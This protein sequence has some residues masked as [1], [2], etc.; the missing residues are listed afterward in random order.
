MS[1]EEYLELGQIQAMEGKF[2]AAL[3]NLTQA[4]SMYIGDNSSDK[5]S[6]QSLEALPSALLSY[7]GLCIAVMEN[8]VEEGMRLCQ[9]AVTKDILRP[10][11]YL[12]LGK[13]Y[14][15]AKQKDRAVKTFRRGIQVTEKNAELIKELEKLG[16]RREP[17]LPFL[18]RRNFLNRYLGRIRQGLTKKEPAQARR[19]RS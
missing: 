7:Y 8:R 15:Q 5:I 9:K 1:K 4:M 16:I 18:P 3:K 10:D 12:N 17:V 2:G 14:L 13:V 6:K 19:S 11:L